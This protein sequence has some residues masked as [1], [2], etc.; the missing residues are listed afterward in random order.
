MEKKKVIVRPIIRVAKTGPE[1]FLSRFCVN[2]YMP[3]S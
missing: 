3:M 1:F 2:A